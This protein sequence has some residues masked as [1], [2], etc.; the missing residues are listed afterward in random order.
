MSK[1][2][3]TVKLEPEHA[4]LE[5]ARRRL[6]LEADELDPDFGVVNVDPEQDLYA[7]LADE[8]TAQKLSQQ[9]EVQGPY[10]NPVIEPFGPPKP[11]G[12]R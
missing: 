7:I 6:G 11:G 5:D 8:R 1:L 12:A 10:A 9:P 3:L 2:M 4:T